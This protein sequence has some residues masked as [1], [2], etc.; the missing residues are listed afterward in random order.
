MYNLFQDYWICPTVTAI[1]THIFAPTPR[2]NAPQLNSLEDAPS[3]WHLAWQKGQRG[4]HRTWEEEIWSRAAELIVHHTSAVPLWVGVISTAWMW[5]LTN[6]GLAE[7]QTSEFTAKYRGLLTH[8]AMD[9]WRARAEIV[10]AA[11]N[12][13]QRLQRS[14]QYQ[15]ATNF[16]QQHHLA[17]THTTHQ[18]MQMNSTEKETLA[19]SNPQKQ[20]TQTTLVDK[21]FAHTRI[22]APSRL[23]AQLRNLQQPKQ[24]TTQADIRAILTPPGPA[25]QAIT[26]ATHTTTTPHTR[27]TNPKRKQRH[28]TRTR[29][30]TKSLLQYW[31]KRRR[32]I[33]RP[34]RSTESVPTPSHTPIPNTQTTDTPQTDTPTTTNAQ[35][36]SHNS[37]PCRIRK[38]TCS[39]SPPASRSTGVI[40]TP[41]RAPS[42]RNPSNTDPT[43]TDRPTDTTAQTPT[44]SSPPKGKRRRTS[45]PEHSPHTTEPHVPPTPPITID[46]TEQTDQPTPRPRSSMQPHDRRRHRP[47]STGRPHTRRGQ[48]SQTVRRPATAAT[49]QLIDLTGDTDDARHRYERKRAA[50]NR[51]PRPPKHK[52]Y[53]T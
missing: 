17:A 33:P 32:T 4:S 26:T 41:P 50:D 34:S 43:H 7:A 27:D 44:H 15:E 11:D 14:T 21:G 38:R 6:G 3:H 22:R 46:L 16:I 18:I 2:G 25:T 9:T 5:L 20:L 13:T 31:P 29:P 8:H 39:P 48:H 28:T 23:P 30:P 47:R 51:P 24:R 37:H 1:F 49:L 10:Y 12:E 45:L 19:T 42:S 35:S 53:R 40:P 36:L 52:K